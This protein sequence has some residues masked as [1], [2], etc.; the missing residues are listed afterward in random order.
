MS[1]PFVEINYELN[2][3]FNRVGSMKRDAK[4]QTEY[5]QADRLWTQLALI[6]DKLAELR[7]Q[8]D[9]E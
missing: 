9:G 7:V 2:V 3:L 1:D 4:N 6:A 8:M 5:R